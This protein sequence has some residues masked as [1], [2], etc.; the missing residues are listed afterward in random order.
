MTCVS[1]SYDLH[2]LLGVVYKEST[3][4]SPVKPPAF[5]WP[6]IRRKTLRYTDWGS[7]RVYLRDTRVEAE[8]VKPLQLA[9]VFGS[10]RTPCGLF[11]N[12]KI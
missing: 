11:A 2:S 5:T 8:I 12:R 7:K 9:T 1:P 3:N 10:R 4:Q 6:K